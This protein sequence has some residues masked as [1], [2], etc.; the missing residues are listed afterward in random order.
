ML[1]AFCL[2]LLC[3]FSLLAYL[4]YHRFCPLLCNDREKEKLKITLAFSKLTDASWNETFQMLIASD[5]YMPNYPF[6]YHSSLAITICPHGVC[7]PPN[8]AMK[9][10]IN[11]AFNYWKD[12][13]SWFR[14]CWWLREHF[15]L[16]DGCICRLTW[17]TAAE[18][19]SLIYELLIVETWMSFQTAVFVCLR[20]WY[21]W[22]C[23]IWWGPACIYLEEL[24]PRCSSASWPFDVCCESP[25]Y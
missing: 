2:I 6:Q 1:L 12:V 18:A 5:C 20:A 21:R 7:F 24:Y 15:N 25:P 4:S 16:N 11:W 13:N 8:R 14:C 19:H 9:D 22:R 10:K 17:I 23:Q 3:Y